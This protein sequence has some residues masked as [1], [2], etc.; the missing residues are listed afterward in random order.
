[1]HTQRAKGI[2][3]IAVSS[4][5]GR[6]GVQL[7]FYQL[8]QVLTALLEEKEH[9]W[10]KFRP[11][12]AFVIVEKWRWCSFNEL[13]AICAAACLAFLWKGA[14]QFC[15][16]PSTLLKTNGILPL[17]QMAAKGEGIQALS[18]VQPHFSCTQLRDSWLS[19]GCSAFIHGQDSLLA[20][21]GLV[22]WVRLWDGVA[23]VV[24]LQHGPNAQ[25]LL[26]FW[27][28]DWQYMRNVKHLCN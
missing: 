20:K 16:I 21:L 19:V 3:V 11:Y 18:S 5:L 8:P 25:T 4:A 7:W 26:L 12:F 13:V 28:C 14:E 2:L 22:V 6:P 27:F 15:I 10:N 23:P 17:F 1:M 9:C 24:V